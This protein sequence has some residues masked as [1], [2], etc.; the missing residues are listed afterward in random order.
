M[1]TE[2]HPPALSRLHALEPSADEMRAML[3]E[4]CHRVL[5]HVASLDDQDAFL[6]CVENLNVE[7]IYVN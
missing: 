7:I 1:S 4:A 3:E 5:R 6:E 2:T